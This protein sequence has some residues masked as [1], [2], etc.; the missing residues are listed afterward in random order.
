MSV[1]IKNVGAPMNMEISYMNIVLYI[2]IYID[3][4]PISF[5]STLS[6]SNDNEEP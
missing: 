3:I 2:Y 1:D 6:L 5:L 4:G